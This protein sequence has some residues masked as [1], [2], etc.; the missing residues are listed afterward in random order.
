M[1][2]TVRAYWLL[3]RTWTRAAAQYPASLAMLTVSQL[4]ITGIDAVAILIIFQHTSSYAGFSLPEVMFLYGTSGVSF[5]IANA[6]IGTVD[7]LGQ[8][9]RAGTFDAILLRPVPALVQ[10][11]A[12]QFSPRRLGKLVQ[13]ALV[14][15]IALATLDVQWT[16]DRIALVPV[17]IVSGVVI[18]AAVWVLGASYQFLAGEAAEAMNAATYGGNYVTQY[19]LSILGRDAIRAL[20]WVIPL[21]FVNWMPALYIL[22]Q[23]DPLGLP[24][25]VRF[26]SPL[27]A[28]LLCL[29][30]ALSWRAGVRHY[31]STGS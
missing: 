9:I 22:D 30:A 28:L 19:P 3:A 6:L 15:C 31:R 1:V 16:V 26:A 12:D 24:G 17:M 27:V 8:H 10:V 11:A 25:S 18:F 23:P 21:A 7:Q 14:L 29:V 5:A 2:D 13:A 4:V 20:T